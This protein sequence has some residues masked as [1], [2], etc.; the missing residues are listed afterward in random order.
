MQGSADF[1]LLST[2]GCPGYEWG[3][4]ALKMN[5]QG[6][7]KQQWTNQRN[8]TQAGFPFPVQHSTNLF[9][10]SN[11]I[12]L[13][14]FSLNLYWVFLSTYKGFSQFTVITATGLVFFSLSF[15]VIIHFPL[16]HSFTRNSPPVIF[17]QLK[18]IE[19][20][21]RMEVQAQFFQLLLIYTT[22]IFKLLTVKMHFLFEVG[23]KV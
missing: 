4:R 17:L 14:Q 9:H 6:Q 20:Y 5:L 1:F 16:A 10:H 7:K 11:I 19:I 13:V 22:R 21:F 3:H 8:C 2:S 23:Y 18:V 12:F 15:S